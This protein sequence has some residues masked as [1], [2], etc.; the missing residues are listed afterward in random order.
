MD[1]Q[2]QGSNELYCS[3]GGKCLATDAAILPTSGTATSDCQVAKDLISKFKLGDLKKIDISSLTN[4]Q[5]TAIATDQC[6]RNCNKDDRVSKV[7]VLINCAEPKSIS[8]PTYDSCGLFSADPLAL[9]NCPTR[10]TSDAMILNPIAG[11]LS[12]FMLVSYL[13]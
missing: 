13:K 12:L 1:K 7:G 2:C 3:C 6:C 9:S 11:V 8:Q 5:R 4:E 10:T